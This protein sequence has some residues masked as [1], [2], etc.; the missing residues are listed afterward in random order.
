MKHIAFN[1]LYRDAGN[2]KNSG[3]V[4][5]GN[6]DRFSVGFVTNALQNS[7]LE[8]VFF[9]AHQIR[10]P[11]R[12]LFSDGCATSDDHCFHELDTV[13]RTSEFPDD[14]FSRSITLFINEVTRQAQKGWIAFNPHEGLPRHF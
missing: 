3:R 9:I 13:E 14:G 2:Y 6:P 8:H 4:I 10:V 11:S 5:F 1:Y 7:F 12:F